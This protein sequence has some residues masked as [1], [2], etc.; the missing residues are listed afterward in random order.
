MNYKFMGTSNSGTLSW[1]LQRISGVILVLVIF[2]HFFSMLKGGALGMNGLVVGT[3]LTFGLFHTFNGF[4]M[5]TD[6]YVSSAGWRAVI[7]GLYWIVGIAV[8]VV[9]LKAF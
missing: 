6:D 1:L 8:L 4:K 7:L 2:V 5:I 9:G 3:V